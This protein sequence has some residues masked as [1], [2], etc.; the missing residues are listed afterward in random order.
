VV[1]MSIDG[2]IWLLFSDGTISKYTKGTSDNFKISGLDAPL[3][4]PSKIVT[5]ADMTNVYVL[6]TGNKRIVTIDK[7]GTY[8]SQVVSDTL[9]SATELIVDEKNKKARFLSSGKIYE[10]GL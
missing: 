8:L 7:K 4:K 2:S 10:V 3:S 9:S 5:N 6:D 1:A